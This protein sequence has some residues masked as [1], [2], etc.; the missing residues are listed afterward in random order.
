MYKHHLLSGMHIQEQM[1][2]HH[3]LRLQRAG[4]SQGSQ[5]WT[6]SIVVSWWFVKRIRHVKCTLVKL[7][8]NGRNPDGITYG[9]CEDRRSSTCYK[10]G[11][12][13]RHFFFWHPSGSSGLACDWSFV[14]WSTGSYIEGKGHL[15]ITTQIGRCSVTYLCENIA[16][17]LWSFITCKYWQVTPFIECIIP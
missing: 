15:L 10:L 1:G 17:Q 6:G 8:L 3:L 14:M 16:V 4:S 9:S 13:S 12:L 11:V 2:C 5:P 7:F